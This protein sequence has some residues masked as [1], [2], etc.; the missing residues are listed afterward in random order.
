MESREAPSLQQESQAL[1]THPIVSA[2]A[3]HKESQP[4]RP[5]TFF[6]YGTLMDPDVI[7]AVTQ[8]D[9]VPVLQDATLE[10]FEMKM[11]LDRYPT[12]LATENTAPTS[13]IRGKTWKATSMEQCL[14]LQTYETSAYKCSRCV[15]KSEDGMSVNAL[16]FTWAGDANDAALSESNGAFDL[17][18]WQ[19][20]YKQYMF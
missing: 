13:T 14:S 18:Y 5:C 1:P 7:R 9:K 17:S 4:F 19:T 16:T 15:V 12:L 20:H 8:S 10:G 11:W 6:F 2:E 3:T